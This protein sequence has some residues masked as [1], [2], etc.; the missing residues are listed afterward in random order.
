M[1]PDCWF[2]ANVPQWIQVSWFYGF[3]CGVLDPSS[4]YNPFFSSSAGFLELHLI[5]GCGSLLLFPSAAGWFQILGKEIEV[6]I[7]HIKA[8]LA[9]RFSQYP[10]VPTW[11]TSSQP[12]TIQHGGWATLLSEPYI[13][14]TF[15]NLSLSL[16]ILFSLSLSLS[17][18]LPPSLSPSLPPSLPPSL[19]CVCGAALF[20]DS[21]VGW[22][23]YG[24]QKRILDSL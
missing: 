12:W 24:G 17:L 16:C 15:C 9:S 5:F 13:I 14:K 3:S 23:G 20:V 8:D 21:Y 10:P 18:S 7:S 1:F 11:H 6:H 19:L 2:S 22:V 4:S